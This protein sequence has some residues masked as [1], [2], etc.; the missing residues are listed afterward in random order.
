MN[1]YFNLPH[2][3]GLDALD[4]WLHNHPESLHARFKEQSFSECARFILLNNYM[5]FNE[6]FY[7]QIKGTAMSG[8]LVPTYLILLMR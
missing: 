8:I 6:E 7:N 2:T 5:K 4:Y 1:L 3:F